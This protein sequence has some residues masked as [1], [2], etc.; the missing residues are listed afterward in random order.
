[1][2]SSTTWVQQSDGTFIC[3][4]PWVWNEYHKLY[5]RSEMRSDGTILRNE[6]S[7]HNPTVDHSEKSNQAANTSI[8][9]AYSSRYDCTPAL[10]NTTINLATHDDHSVPQPTPPA[11]VPNTSASRAPPP[12]R[13]ISCTEWLW[14]RKYHQW[15]RYN[16]K[17][18]GTM[19]T[20]RAY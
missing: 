1:M 11:D 19:T 12:V 3:K 2:S 9:S 7:E 16:T 15:Y 6:W 17:S 20:Y 13:T 8:K 14:S 5:Y 4:T 18:D 10:V